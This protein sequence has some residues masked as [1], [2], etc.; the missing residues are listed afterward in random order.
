[1]TTTII[2]QTTIIESIR[3]RRLD[4]ATRA[5]AEQGLRLTHSEADDLGAEAIEWAARRLGLRVITDDA[6][7]SLAPRD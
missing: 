6:G 3:A 7:V 5:A 4:D 1:M 2:S